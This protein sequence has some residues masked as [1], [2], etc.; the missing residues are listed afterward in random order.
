[1]NGRRIWIF[2]TEKMQ[3]CCFRHSPLKPNRLFKRVRNWCKS[4]AETRTTD[5]GAEK[6]KFGEKFE[7]VGNF[8]EQFRAFPE[9][10]TYWS[11]SRPDGWKRGRRINLKIS[12]CVSMCVSL[13]DTLFTLLKPR[14]TQGR[15]LT[16]SHSVSPLAPSCGT[17]VQHKKGP[18]QPIQSFWNLTD[19]PASRCH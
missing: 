7:N 13:T 10:P 3:M 17:P 19:M 11:R 14:Q 12:L 1:M 16:V 4:R 18:H 9:T 8:G 2:E 15:V 6:Q 5:R